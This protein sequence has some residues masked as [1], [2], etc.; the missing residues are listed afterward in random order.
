LKY[1]GLSP[2]EIWMSESQERMVTAVAPQNIEEFQKICQKYN[3]ESSVLG[4]FDGSN[5]LSVF[6]WGEAVADLDY[7]FLKHGLSQRVMNAKY[8]KPSFDEQIPNT[9]THW[10]GTIKKV[11]SHGNVCSKEPIV[12]QYDHTVQGTNVLAPFTGV[13]L[14]GP[15]DAVVITPILGKDY[16]M[17]QSHGLN[18]T[19]NRIDPYWGSVWA[20]TE[21]MANY[22]AVGGDPKTAALIN[23]YIWPYPD[24]QS[25]GS[26][27]KS[28]DA[29]CDFMDA[30]KRPVVSGKDSLSSTYRDKD[31]EVIK[32][33]PVLCM[34]VFGKITDV[35]KTVTSDFKKHDSTLVLVGKM[36]ENMGGSIYFDINGTIGNEVP[37]VDLEILPKVLESVHDAVTSGDVLACH[38]VSEGGVITTVSEMC[39]GGDCGVDLRLDFVDQ[40][41]DMFLF[42]ETAGCF[43]M[44]V[45]NE[46]RANELFRDIPHQI[47]G[48]TKKEKE[49]TVKSNNTQFSASVDE[50]KQA[51]KEPMRK[52]F[53]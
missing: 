6:Y 3:V 14:D 13:H 30:V 4:H 37:K 40:R 46:E 15:N 2:W 18:P 36:D 43:V 25:L 28:V 41:P 27:D 34:S 32:I 29:V 9:P 50:L 12:R 20:A 24:E 52:I 5:K 11:L 44:E 1:L 31:G 38:D 8:E 23:N 10:V 7:D 53:H 35:R 49:I 45:E 26:L 51:W 42:N 33:P 17:V 19:L 47:L 21:A 39:F 48:K 22:V 16:G